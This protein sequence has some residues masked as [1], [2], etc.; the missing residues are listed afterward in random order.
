MTTSAKGIRILGLITVLFI[1][2]ILN[3]MLTAK[4]NS[5]GYTAPTLDVE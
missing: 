4:E 2:Y 3:Y 1:S 5:G